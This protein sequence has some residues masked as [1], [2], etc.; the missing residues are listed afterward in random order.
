[1]SVG[2]YG[3]LPSHGDF[4]SRSVASGFLDR[5]DAWLQAGVAQSHSDLGESWLDLFLTSPV[6]RFALQNG[7]VGGSAFAG[8]LLPSVDRVGRYFP[9]TIVSELPTGTHPQI[10]S[11]GAA[12]W[13]DWVEAVA[14]RALEE[15]IL[16]LESFL[17][18][19]RASEQMLGDERLCAQPIAVAGSGFPGESA[20]WRFSADTEADMGRF[21]ARLSTGLTADTLT[22][23]ALW[24]S[25]GSERV[26]PSVLMTRGLPP[27]ATFQDFLRTDWNVAWR[28]EVPANVPPVGATVGASLQCRSAAL[29][30]TGSQR[31]E[32]QDCYV[33]RRAD[34]FWLVADGMGG[35]Q[36]GGYASQLA[37]QFVMAAEIVGDVHTM[38]NGAAQALQAAN[39]Q[40]RRRAAA[41]PGFDAGTTVLAV[42]IRDDS[43][44][45]QWAGDSRLY[46]LR[47]GTI[48]QLTRDHTVANDPGAVA[49][50]ED[51]H[52]LTRALGSSDVL[53][54][55][56]VR[57]DSLEGDRYLLCSDG[58]YG[59]L[60]S[61]EIARLLGASD[62][63][64]AASGLIALALRRGG[65]DNMT[66]VVID[67]FA[68]GTGTQ[69]RTG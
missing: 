35:H 44:I 41:E 59:D 24:W 14:R 12:A 3:K 66:A 38:A 45:V 57:F 61:E 52:V 6:W 17:L 29:T 2:F 64:S 39:A 49:S 68:N 16:D 9:L 20:L 65:G 67:V 13:F 47:G 1:M 21:H 15:E 42:C 63:A 19:L 23:L 58:L 40:L 43:G 25:S 46:R 30:D 69:T 22:P 10:V 11:V 34:G 37:A 50:E 27:A 48:T 54:L 53:E 33:E 36:A 56:R 51:A 5:W 31:T 28:S 32:N 18:E 60:T 4:V 26:R 8:I 62:C 7:V 55:D